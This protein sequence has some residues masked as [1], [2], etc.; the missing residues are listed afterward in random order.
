MS[1]FMAPYNTTGTAEIDPLTGL[2]KKK[3][4]AGAGGRVG[5]VAMFNQADID[6]SLAVNPQG[7]FGPSGGVDYSMGAKAPGMPDYAALIKAALGPMTAQFGADSAADLGTR[8]QQLI[9]ALGQFGEQFDLTGANKAFG[10]SFVG[11]SGLGE[12]LPQA[13]ALAQQTTDAGMS[14][15]ARSTKAHKDSVRAIKNALAARGA[16]RSGEA[17]YQLQEAQGAFDTGQYDAR[18]QVQD[19]M[20]AVNQGYAQAQR[21]RQMQMAAAQ[22]EEA[23]RQAALNPGIANPPGGSFSS[24]VGGAGTPGLPPRPQANTAPV[25]PQTWDQYV[26]AKEAENKRTGAAADGSEYSN[27]ETAAQRAARLRSEALNK[28]YGLG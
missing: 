9:R 5:P 27:I 26:A 7:G 12:L 11:E 18:Q 15:T 28:Q 6:A 21:E 1:S 17:G 14:F 3:K 23:G 2:P 19:F 10:E 25:S 24:L 16:L 4:Q 20:G 13:N 8:N 22:R